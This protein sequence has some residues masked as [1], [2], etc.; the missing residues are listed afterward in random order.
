MRTACYLRFSSDAQRDASIRDQLR[1]VEAYCAR[2]EVSWTAVI[3][4]STPAHQRPKPL[5]RSADTTTRNNATSRG[6]PAWF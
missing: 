1:N 4:P 6:R 2:A 5:A 3:K